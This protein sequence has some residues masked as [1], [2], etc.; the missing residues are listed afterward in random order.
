[1][2]ENCGHGLIRWDI[3]ERHLSKGGLSLGNFKK[4]N[5]TLTSKW[6]W[7]FLREPKAL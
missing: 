3:L 4:R 6:L 7:R 2:E 1:M 5:Q